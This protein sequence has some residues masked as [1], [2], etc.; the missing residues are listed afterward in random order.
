MSQTT[1]TISVNVDVTNPGQ[2]FACCG[3]LELADRLWPGAEGW[4][5]G[6]CFHVACTAEPC[7]LIAGVVDALMGCTV[8][9][10]ESEDPKTAPLFLS[11][12]IAMRLDWWLTHGEVNRFFKTW[13][14]N[15]TSR[16]MFE[17][18]RKPLRRLRGQALAKPEQILTLDQRLQ[19]SYG[20]DSAV[21]WDALNIGFSLNEHA[22]LK[23][24]PTRPFVE[25][26][27]TIG[28]QRF[29]PRVRVSGS[30]KQA[31]AIVNYATW[32]VP[33]PPIVAGIAMLGQLPHIIG[34]GLCTRSVTRG[35][36]KGLDRARTVV[37]EA[38]A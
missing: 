30:G 32:R 14:S 22:G 33:L 23:Q 38:H 18:W 28:L 25:L 5:S 1:S 3:L 11:N 19:G 34:E 21:G 36:F 15:A 26:L 2:F 6:P 10:Q 9:A 7:E 20:F 24:M 8:Y 13:A 37:G 29:F 27:G 17:K 16:Q 4:F 35:S 12:P 31:R